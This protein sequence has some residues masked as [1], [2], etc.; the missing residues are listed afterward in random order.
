VAL[1][2]ESPPATRRRPLVPVLG[3]AA[4]VGAVHV[5]LSGRYGF[6]Q[7]ELYLLAA[8]RHPALGYVD[9]PPLA[10]LAARGITAVVGE[11][12]WALRL[13][14]GA[15]HAGLV[16]AVAGIAS[17]LGGR[18]RTLLLAAL[19][20]ATMP[21]FVAAGA[22]FDPGSLGLL[23]WAL[24]L[25]AVA[26]VLAGSDPRWWL[27]AGA[28]LGATLES[29]WTGP[30]LALGLVLGLVL[31][32]G[33][34][35]HLR[36]GWPAL[37]LLVALAV[38]LPNLVWQALNGWPARELHAAAVAPAGEDGLADFVIRQIVLAGPAG[39]VL[40][41]A[42]VV[43]AW[44]RPPW[45]ALAVPAVVVA[46]GLA[47]VGARA[48]DLGFAYV[49]VIPAGVAAADYWAAD[50]S[51][52]WHQAIAGVAAGLILLPLAA[53]AT[54]LDVYEDLYLSVDPSLAEEVG[55]PETAALVARVYDIL[56]AGEKQAARVVT[57]HAGVAATLDLYGPARGLPRSHVLSADR[58]YADWWPH[59]EPTGTV[60]FVG[61]TRQALEPYCDAMGPI[62]ILGN[63]RNIR[64]EAFESTISVCNVMKVTSGA[65]RAGLSRW[66]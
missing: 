63:D 31:A 37:G 64:N 3:L 49:A 46:A 56:P 34:R 25:W 21:V 29:T 54:S 48:E 36:S 42:G 53:P 39:V 33:A 7:D 10:P 9:Q 51:R 8:G 2:A 5:V 4:G 12:L 17:A 62:A 15:A 24:A 60:I 50:D 47:V 14:S 55:G 35:R 57:A 22:R 1:T 23:F 27:G 65:L 19:A 41:V 59:H 6:H 26:S 58:S 43:W 28:A 30:L 45:R 32:P 66:D 18:P 61:Y 52:R 13:V 20:A 11:H 38:W 40:G 44:R 16:V